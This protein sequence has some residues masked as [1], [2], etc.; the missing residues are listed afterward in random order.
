MA[1]WVGWAAAQLNHFQ[2][3]RLVV[4]LGGCWL[5]LLAGWFCPDPGPSFAFALALALA[6]ESSRWMSPPAVR[7]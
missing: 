3:Q 2:V 7:S 6:L 1:S 4:R 5:W